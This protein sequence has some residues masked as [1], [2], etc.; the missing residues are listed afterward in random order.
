MLEIIAI[1]IFFTSI[2]GIL[3]LLFRKIPVLTGFPGTFENSARESFIFKFKNNIRER[4]TREK[5]N[6]FFQKTL[7]RIKILVLKLEK[8]IDNSL[9]KLRKES[10]NNRNKTDKPS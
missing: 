2:T 3:I 7:S 5:K 1:I 6:K 4:F 8:K 9:Q 10:K